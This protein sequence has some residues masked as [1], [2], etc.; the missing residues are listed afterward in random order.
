MEIKSKEYITRIEIGYDD[1]ERDAVSDWISNQGFEELR[2]EELQ[3]PSNTYTGYA[4]KRVRLHFAQT[5]SDE[6]NFSEAS[7]NFI[8]S[9]LPTRLKRRVDISS[10]KRIESDI[11]EYSDVVEYRVNSSLTKVRVY[12]QKRGE[13]F[14]AIAWSERT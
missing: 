2:G 14:I 9:N 3:F 11:Y 5:S 13:K 1:H 6:L 12:L 10:S 8:Q 7:A 4:E